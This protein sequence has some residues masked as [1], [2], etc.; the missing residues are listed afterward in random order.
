MESG[1]LSTHLGPWWKR[2]CVQHP[3]SFL[4]PPKESGSRIFSTPLPLSLS[5]P[6]LPYLTT[7]PSTI[8]L[9]RLPAVQSISLVNHSLKRNT[10]RR[11]IRI[12]SRLEEERSLHRYNPFRKFLD[13]RSCSKTR[14]NS[15]N[16]S[17]FWDFWI[18][19]WK[20]REI[21]ERFVNFSKILNHIFL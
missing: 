8:A 5:T 4:S 15:C 12:N 9:L 14:W 16:E 2:K 11:I 3:P 13:H 6:I 1:R 10:S 18:I 20:T 7:Q 21:I 19:K 17:F